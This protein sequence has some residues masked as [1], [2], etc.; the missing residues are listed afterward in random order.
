MP[1]G[2]KPGTQGKKSSPSDWGW[3]LDGLGH[4]LGDG[5]G[6]ALRDRLWDGLR[7][8]LGG[9]WERL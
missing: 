8:S 5:L 4:G 7:H 3:V 2:T 1:A 9:T 6:D